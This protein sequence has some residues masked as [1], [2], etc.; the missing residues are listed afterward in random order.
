MK[1]IFILDWDD[2]L[3]PTSWVNKHNNLNIFDFSKLDYYLSLFIQHIMHHGV[4]IIVTNALPNWIDISLSVLP[5]TKYILNIHNIQFRYPRLENKYQSNTNLSKVDTF[6]DIYMKHKN[7][8]PLNII[9][10][11][12]DIYEYIASK[13][14]INIKGYKK[15]HFI[16]IKKQSD[17]DS[18]INQINH[19]GKNI[20]NLK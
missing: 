7:N 12:D 1:T 19:I 9:C 4:V 20:Y 15:I 11:G 5:N 6:I 16:R 13:K 14:L 10:I 17:Y 3:F 8:V 2:T 18:L